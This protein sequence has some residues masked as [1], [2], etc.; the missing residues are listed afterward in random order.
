MYGCDGVTSEILRRSADLLQGSGVIH[1]GAPAAEHPTRL[2]RPAQPTHR[3]HE[4][5][6]S[7]RYI[8]IAVCAVI[9]SADS[10]LAV[11][12]YG[13]AR[14]DWLAT[15]L[16]LPNGIPSHDTFGRVFARLDPE[17]LEACFLRWV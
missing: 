2:C 14:R 8:T 1:G 17:A 9:S 15:F 5:P 6:P 11:E 4:T 3:A 16:E 13:L 10:W 12:H 7:A